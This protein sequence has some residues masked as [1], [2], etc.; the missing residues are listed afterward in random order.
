MKLN[1][2]SDKFSEKT[3]FSIMNRLKSLNMFV[4]VGNRIPKIIEGTNFLKINVK[5]L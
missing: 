4:V 1:L 5:S 2:A 3:F